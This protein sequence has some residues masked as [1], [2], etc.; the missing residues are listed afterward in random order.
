MA[1]CDTVCAQSASVCGVC[2]GLFV[3]GGCVHKDIYVHTVCVTICI[4]IICLYV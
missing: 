4:Y 3:C 2:D 1:V